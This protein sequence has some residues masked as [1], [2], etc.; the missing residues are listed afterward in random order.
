MFNFLCKRAVQKHS[1]E[2]SISFEPD[3][4]SAC[5]SLF[6]V[7]VERN[8]KLFSFSLGNAFHSLCTGVNDYT[9]T[10]TM[11]KQELSLK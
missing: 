7:G 9:G 6:A 8:D 4:F 11:M 5:F 2:F 10:G 3:K 1:F